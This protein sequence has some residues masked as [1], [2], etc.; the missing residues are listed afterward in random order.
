MEDFVVRGVLMY[1]VVQGLDCICGVLCVQ[2]AFE[3]R[4]RKELLVSYNTVA[5]P[6]S[7]CAITAVGLQ[8]FRSASR[9]A[10]R[11]EAVRHI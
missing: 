2:P 4:T 10:S 7:G 3:L 5:A 9:V 1:F 11:T 8:P 6:K